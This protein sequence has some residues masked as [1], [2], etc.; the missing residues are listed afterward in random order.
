[1]AS[2]LAVPNL[3]LSRVVELLTRRRAAR[4]IRLLIFWNTTTCKFRQASAVQSSTVPRQYFDL[5]SR[6]AIFNLKVATYIIRIP[7][8]GFDRYDKAGTLWSAQT[9][10][11]N[12]RDNKNSFYKLQVLERDPGVSARAAPS[13][14]YLFK[15]W[16]ECVTAPLPMT[17]RYTHPHTLVHLRSL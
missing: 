10:N 7:G 5:L 14:Y 17:P 9:T 15:S 2:W 8:V 6:V 16:G 11:V 12:L 1:V 4:E 13:Q 3:S